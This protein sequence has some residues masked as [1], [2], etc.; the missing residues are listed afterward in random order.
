[1]WDLLRPRTKSQDGMV[2]SQQ[3]T[4]IKASRNIVELLDKLEKIK[5][6]VI[7]DIPDVKQVVQWGAPRGLEQFAQ[8]SGCAGRDGRQSLSIWT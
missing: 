1:M 5:E 8:E 2:Q 6:T 3:N 4:V 7:D